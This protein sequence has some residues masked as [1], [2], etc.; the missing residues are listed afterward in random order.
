LLKPQIKTFYPN[1]FSNKRTESEYSLDNK[2]GRKV[3]IND[4]ITMRNGMPFRNLGDKNFSNPEYTANFFTEG[5]KNA[6]S[7]TVSKH[8]DN[9]YQ[10]L[11]L[12]IKSLNPEKLWNNKQKKELKD[13]DINYVKS[14][15]EWEMA[16]IPKPVKVDPKIA[17]ASPI[18]GK[19]PAK[20]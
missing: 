6:I 2:M 18:K 9:F 17:N 19:A 11:D 15:N 8:S 13:Y 20:K 3:K 14:L 10:T 12:E 4:L 1:S 7:K 16:N 5:G